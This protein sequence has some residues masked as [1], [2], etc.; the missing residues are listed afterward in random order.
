MSLT[1]YKIVLCGEYSAGKTSLVQRLIRG[2]FDEKCSST[3][4][5]S[6]NVWHTVSPRQMKI[7]IWDTAGQERFSGLLPMYLRQADVILY[8]W[9]YNVPLDPKKIAN[10]LTNA[11][12]LCHDCVVYFV[13][14]K[15]DTATDFGVAKEKFEA[16]CSEQEHLWFTSS[17]TN[18]GISE[19]FNDVS[20]Q[21]SKRVKH[22]SKVYTVDLADPEPKNCCRII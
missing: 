2:T 20:E 16:F 22:D 14:T 12:E 19:M 15:I 21:L 18:D 1:D 6:Y 10:T 17:L 7:G 3:I 13:V 5:A 9:E 4:G 8:C 11:R